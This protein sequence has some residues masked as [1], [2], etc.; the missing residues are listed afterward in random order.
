MFPIFGGS[1]PRQA[2]HI[3]RILPGRVIS[4]PA[5]LSGEPDGLVDALIT[6][7]APLDGTR[8][9]GLVEYLEHI[10]PR[11]RGLVYA[12][13]LLANGARVVD[14][15]VMS[16]VYKLKSVER[17]AP[18]FTYYRDISLFEKMSKNYGNGI[19]KTAATGN[20]RL[21]YDGTV[22]PAEITQ[23][24]FKSYTIPITANGRLPVAL[25]GRKLNL[26][27]IREKN[28]RF[29]ICYAAKDDLVDTGAAL[30]PADFVDVELTRFPK[31]HAAIATSWSD[32]ESEYALR[33][34]FPGDQRGPVRFQLDLNEE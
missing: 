20:H 16:R 19:N 13:K 4:L 32:P 27:Y 6:C 18:L 33:K 5:V 1:A 9:R 34:V 22:L 31:G 7:V 3:E 24:R 28:I 14:G 30:A 10:T 23:L 2:V 21:M 25:F 12:E 11:F 8:S 17:E 26:D 15:Q 29:Q